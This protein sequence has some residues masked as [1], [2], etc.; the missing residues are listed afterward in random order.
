MA[1]KPAE[2]S[3]FGGV[4]CNPC[5]DTTQMTA[6]ITTAHT[7]KIF[8]LGQAVTLWLNT[9]SSWGASREVGLTWRQRSQEQACRAVD[10]WAPVKY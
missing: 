3:G 10:S 6:M 7:I 9:F 4:G 1:E 5:H 2:S 8:L